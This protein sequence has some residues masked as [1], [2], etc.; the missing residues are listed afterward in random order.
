ML[1]V[2]I[3]IDFSLIGFLNVYAYFLLIAYLG[4]TISTKILKLFIALVMIS[5]YFD[6]VR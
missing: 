5:F 1:C 2:G 4:S 3:P 6:K